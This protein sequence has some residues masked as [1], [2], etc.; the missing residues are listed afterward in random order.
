MPLA[1]SPP[2]SL[3]KAPSP[4]RQLLGDG[5]YLGSPARLIHF[6]LGQAD[7]VDR[8]TVH[9]PSGIEQ[10]L[11]DLPACQRL[12]LLEPAVTL[13][14]ILA[15]TYISGELQL[16]ARLRN[17]GTLTETVTMK[18]RVTTAAGAEIEGTITGSLAGGEESVVTVK[19]GVDPATYV[20][21]QGASVACLAEVYA[22]GSHDHGEELVVLP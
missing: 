19:I 15:P 9:W 4:K 10:V 3:P 1:F 2:P 16:N 17:R 22:S 21:W 8:L 12:T 11:I 18:M 7:A 5:S 6:G 13:E 14:D 20:A